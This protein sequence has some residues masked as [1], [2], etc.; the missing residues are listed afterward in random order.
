MATTA[1]AAY[2][3]GERGLCHRRAKTPPTTYA[4]DAGEN[5]PAASESPAYAA[6]ERGLCRR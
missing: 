2:A 6:G 5:R 4:R 1:P 3:A